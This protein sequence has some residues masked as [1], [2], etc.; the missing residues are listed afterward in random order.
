MITLEH[1]CVT[2]SKHVTT[3]RFLLWSSKQF[4]RDALEMLLKL[5]TSTSSSRCRSDRECRERDLSKEVWNRS[6][7]CS[8]LRHSFES[9][10]IFRYFLFLVCTAKL[11]LWY[12]FFSYASLEY[13][14]EQFNQES[15]KRYV[16]NWTVPRS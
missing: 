12:R 6:S 1:F 14:I 9:W 15:L 2:S 4:S 5:G 8:S 16:A 7:L 10:S 3:R 13:H 11:Q